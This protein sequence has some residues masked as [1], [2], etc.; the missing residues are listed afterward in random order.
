MRRL[1]GKRWRR[2][3]TLIELAVVTAMISSIPAASY[4]RVKQ[5]AVQT[6]CINNLQ[7]IGQ[8]LVMYLDENGGAFPK[9]AFY[10]KDPEKGADSIRQII[11]SDKR[12]WIC[13][14]LPDKLQEKGLTF[15]Y[16]DTLKDAS[17]V[18]DPAKKWVLIEMCCVSAQAPLPHPDGYNILFADG[19][20][21]TSRVLP[22]TITDIQKA[23]IRRIEWRLQQYAAAGR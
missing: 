21:A 7:Q 17:S 23:E 19:H 8:L 11:G 10:P 4:V 9:A 2:G 1:L 22:K 18:Q 3:F 14:G 6:E 5:K 13:P 15:V 20:V 16:N 12:L